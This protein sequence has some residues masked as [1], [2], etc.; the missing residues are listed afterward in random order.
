MTACRF[1]ADDQ[2]RMLRNRHHKDCNTSGCEGCTPCEERHCSMDFCTGRHLD[3]SE[4]Q[5]CA[6]C[7]GR[8]RTDVSRILALCRSEMVVEEL[9]ERGPR[10]QAAW[11][12]GPTAGVIS[13]HRKEDEALAGK[14]PKGWLEDNQHEYHPAWVLGCWDLVVRQHYGHDIENGVTIKA[15]AAYLDGL[16]TEIARDP[17]LDFSIL[18][19]DMHRT[20]TMLELV[21]PVDRGPQTGAP[22]PTCERPLV[23]IYEPVDTTGDKDRWHCKTC[24]TWRTVEEYDLFVDSVYLGNASALTASQIHAQYGVAEGTVYR[25]GLPSSD[26]NGNEVPPKVRK[27]GRNDLGLQLYDVADVKAQIARRNPTKESA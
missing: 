7:Q 11:L 3:Q 20:V 22:C 26:T 9:L 8:V 14:L 4:N 19:R 10:S 13:W 15:A 24:K 27:R 23:K 6:Q 16:L 5:A 25:W 1:V 18:A 17:G 12:V 21:L 2:P